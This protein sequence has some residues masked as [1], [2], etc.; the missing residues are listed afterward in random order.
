MDYCKYFNDVAVNE[1]LHKSL[2]SL[3][4][5][6]HKFDLPFWSRYEF[7]KRISSPFYHKLHIAQLNVMYDLTGVAIYKNYADKWQKYQENWFYRKLA[8][9]IKAFQKVFE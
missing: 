9:V 3:E 8:F 7:G 1:V 5:Y 4:K 6:L 2:K